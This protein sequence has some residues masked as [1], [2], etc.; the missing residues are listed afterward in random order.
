MVEC[1]SCGLYK[2]VSPPNEKDLLA[3]LKGWTLSACYNPETR[4]GRL[5]DAEYQITQINSHSGVGTV[6]DVGCASGFFLKVARDHGWEIGG[7]DISLAGIDWG[8]KNYQIDI[9]YDFFENVDL[10]ANSQDCVVMWNTLE[11]TYNP[12][13]TVRKAKVVLKPGGLLYIKIPEKGTL[14]LLQKHYESWHFFEFSE[15][16]L[17]DYLVSAGFEKVYTKTYWDVDVPETEYMFRLVG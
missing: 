11:H 10:D 13:S 12:A 2:K 14:E 15:K 5:D 6:Y 3:L 16:C 1:G 4:K 9:T 8:K 17:V 7:N